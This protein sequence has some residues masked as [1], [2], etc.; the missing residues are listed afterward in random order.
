MLIKKLSLKKVVKKT[1]L[2]LIE[3][4]LKIDYQVFDFGVMVNGI[5]GHYPKEYGASYNYF[6]EIQVDG[7][8]TTSGIS[9]VAYKDDMVLSFVETSTLSKFDQSVDDF[10]Y[11]FIE[12][13]LTA[14]LSDD[15]VDYIVFSFIRPV[16]DRK[17]Y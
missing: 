5:E 13:N 3:D 17:I 15:Y 8:K 7:I 9:D 10:I 11:S 1:T 2:E 16:K 6:Y 12:N 14:Y 4:N